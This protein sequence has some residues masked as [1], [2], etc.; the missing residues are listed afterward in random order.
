M[1]IEIEKISV[2]DRIRKD[3]G[4]ID[5]LA[6]DIKENGLINPPVVIPES[7]GTFTLLAGERRIRAL[8]SLGK[9]DVE[10]RTWTTLTDEQKLNIEISENEVR[11]DFSKAE[12]V[13]Y[14]RRLERI[15]AAKAEERMKAG[16][17]DPS[18][19][20]D[21]GKRTD[22]IVA[23]KIGIGGKDTYRKEK[24]IVANKD[25]LDPEDF[26]DWDEGKLSTNKAFQKVREKLKEQEIELK[27]KEE[28]ITN[29]EKELIE[30]K[31]IISEREQKVASLEQELKESKEQ[32]I[33]IKEKIVYPDDYEK[34][35]DELKSTK[36]ELHK[37]EID[38]NFMSS[39]YENK[40]KENQELKKQI[41]TMTE[42]SPKI[43]YEEHLKNSSLVFCSKVNSFIED[44]GGFIWLSDKINELPDFERTGYIQAVNAIKSWA[45][46]MDY[47]INN[48]LKEIK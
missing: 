41:K 33:Q 48:K 31:N 38:S 3:F 19:N 21:K 29:K 2:K 24:S 37:H 12:R 18:L 25:L 27:T 22:E 47:N 1:L 43:K 17:A 7:D 10:V 23:K 16:K 6:Q 46:T 9:K 40:V 34:I 44:A 30:Q 4:D 45:D 36:E 39:Q 35:K 28:I 14:G 5:E 15:E 26:A 8:K 42:E 32:K 20:S 13:E 11:K